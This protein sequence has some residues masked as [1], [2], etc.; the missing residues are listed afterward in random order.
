MSTVS[1]DTTREPITR[2]QLR[3]VVGT[4]IGAEPNAF[5]EDAD[6][7]GLGLDS[8]RAIQLVNRL[9]QA[10]MRMSVRELTAEPTLA[11]LQRRIETPED[12]QSTTR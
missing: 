9:R 7:T 12:G 1:A 11:A 6:L 3:E 5:P 10:G 8:L 4:V 2:D